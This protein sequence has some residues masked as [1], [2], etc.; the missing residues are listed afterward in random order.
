[1]PSGRT[2][3]GGG[4]FLPI[5]FTE[6]EIFTPSEYIEEGVVPMIFQKH[7]C[8]SWLLTKRFSRSVRYLS[9]LQ[10]CSSGANKQKRNNR[11]ATNIAVI[12]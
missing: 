7:L 2:S 3:N 1:M 4:C 8:L 12:S 10:L 5:K 11:P 9:R 6:G